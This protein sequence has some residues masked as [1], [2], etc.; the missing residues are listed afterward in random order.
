MIG[1]YGILLSTL[2]SFM[3][4]SLFILPKLLAGKSLLVWLFISP[5]ILSIAQNLARL[6]YKIPEA[7][8]PYGYVSSLFGKRIGFIIGFLHL[9]AIFSQQ[10]IIL[11]SLEWSFV[12]LMNFLFISLLFTCMTFKSNIYLYNLL[13]ILK[14]M[15]YTILL[16]LH[17]FNADYN[18]TIKIDTMNFGYSCLAILFAFAGIEFNTINKKTQI[19]NP[20]ETI[21][22]AIYIG[23]I[24]AILIFSLSH[25]IFNNDPL[26]IAQNYNMYYLINLNIILTI[27]Y[28]LSFGNFILH[29]LTYELF[30]LAKRE[31]NLFIC[32]II[33]IQSILLL[34]GYTNLS[35]YLKVSDFMLSIVY[36]AIICCNHKLYGLDL[37]TFT[38]YI[39]VLM[40]FE[41]CCNFTL[42]QTLYLLLIA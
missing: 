2:G 30:N 20:R 1:F 38:G 35:I 10:V 39:A 3:G 15:P 12:Y 40:M 23:V 13:N 28:S 27:F 4:A 16:L 6:N 22:K 8:G 9:I 36:L 31:S 25:I 33:I 37:S 7:N 17:A 19:D 14:F 18:L 26:I 42:T 11:Q 5:I 34:I 21:S 32:V 29:F 41:S 24:L